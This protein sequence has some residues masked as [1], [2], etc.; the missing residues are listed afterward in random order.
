M[1][2][3]DSTPLLQVDDF[4]VIPSLIENG[5]AAHKLRSLQITIEGIKAL[6]GMR[7]TAREQR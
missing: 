1:R 7:K 3:L 6:D 5:W 4:P 2:W